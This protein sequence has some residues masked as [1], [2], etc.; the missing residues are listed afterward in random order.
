MRIDNVAT[1][2]I[3]VTEAVR[4]ELNKVKVVPRESYDDVLR[5]LLKMP[6]REIR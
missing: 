5:R 1:K 2:Y 4:A 3:P 6:K